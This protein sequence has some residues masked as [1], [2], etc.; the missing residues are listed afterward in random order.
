V[1]LRHLLHQTVLIRVGGSQGLESLVTGVDDTRGTVR[2][3]Y[4]ML[5]RPQ[6]AWVELNLIDDPRG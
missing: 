1:R 4:H 3:L 2:V 5:G 6:E